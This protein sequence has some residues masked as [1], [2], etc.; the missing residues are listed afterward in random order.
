MMF[1]SRV[2]YGISYKQNQKSF[3]IYRRKYMHNLKVCVNSENF[4]G[5]KSVEIVTMNIFL[6]SQIDKVLMFDSDKYQTGR[7]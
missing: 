5:G 6:V 3:D 2:R 7:L 1:G 4:E